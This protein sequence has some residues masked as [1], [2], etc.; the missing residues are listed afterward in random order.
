MDAILNTTRGSA[1][2]LNNTLQ[3][4]EGL[5]NQRMDLLS[6]YCLAHPNATTSRCLTGFYGYVLNF[7]ANTAFC[8]LFVV[9]LMAYVI[10]FCAKRRA[11]DFTVAMVLGCLCEVLGYSGR[12]WSQQDQFENTP[13]FLQ[14]CCLT[15]GPAFMAAG[16]YL[17]LR[18][19]VQCFGPQH[20]RI[21]PEWYTRFVCI[22]WLARL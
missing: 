4:K 9:V 2:D 13:F 7:R 22:R 21:P 14:I 20:S 11:R 5:D 8:A 10:A 16:L 15:I 18:R 3:A 12:A 1:L 17:C 19:I 6:K